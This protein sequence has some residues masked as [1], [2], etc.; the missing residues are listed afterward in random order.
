MKKLKIKVITP[1]VARHV[2]DLN[3][4]KNHN[5]FI[6]EKRILTHNCDGLTPSA[7][8]GLRNF[9]EEFSKNCGFIFTCNFKNRIIEPLRNSRLTIVD[10][11]I[12][13]DERPAIAGQFFSRHANDQ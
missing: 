1:G 2:Y 7:Q 4:P 11:A 9:I 8:A 12:D 13:K 10:F 3:V 6:L 5:F